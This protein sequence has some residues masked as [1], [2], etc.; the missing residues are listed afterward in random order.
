MKS[1]I[2]L[3]VPTFLLAQPGAPAPAQHGR[4]YVVLI[5]ID[6]MRPEYLDRID[7]PNIGRVMARG[8]RADGMRPAFPTKTYPN[9]YTVVTGLYVENHGIVANHFFDPER[10]ARYSMY[11]SLAVTDG[12]W[13]RGEP[14]WSTAEKQGVRA[15]SYF[16]PGSEAAIAGARP[17][18]YK[19]YDGGVSNTARA[20]SA[21]AW[22]SLPAERRPHMISL[23]FSAVDETGH[24]HGPFSHQVDTATKAIDAAVG[25][26]IT[27]IERLSLRD[28]VYLILVS[29]HG[30]SETSPRW[31]AALDTLIDLAGVRVA[32]AGP[33]A[34]LHVTGGVE[35]ARVLRDSINRR[36][37]HGRAYLRA[38]VP[39]R[40]RY[41]RDPRVGD[42][43]VIM[44]DHYQVGSADRP[45]HEGTAAHGW[46]P[47]ETSMHAIFVAMGPGIPAGK[48]IPV[49]DNVHVYDFMA[50][51]LGLVPAPNDGLPGYLASLI[52]H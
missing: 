41:A 18:I 7:L 47:V 49:F 35:R 43:V 10:N 21:V 27:G 32:D 13:Y 40:L 30:M 14:I 12:S 22:L 9:H 6:G 5:S 31:Y 2:A 17:S 11:D 48:R 1:L 50:G 28:S 19:K 8:V 29:D 20:D 37:R 51:V 25:R 4:P 36:M 33:N 42:L 38:E 39:G 3:C 34:N 16:W 44:D 23:Y 45:P 15:A 26:L 46:E 52:S 24:R